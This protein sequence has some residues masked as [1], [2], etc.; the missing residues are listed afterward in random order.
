MFWAKTRMGW[1]E[2]NAQEEENK[3][4]KNNP[5][6]TI[7][8]NV[9]DARKMPSLNSQQYEFTQLPNKFRAFV[10]GFGSGKTWVGCA[11][12]CLHF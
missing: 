6:N 2:T 11:N 7:T 8:I 3:E 5:K 4:A 10:A 1:K 12:L 9:V